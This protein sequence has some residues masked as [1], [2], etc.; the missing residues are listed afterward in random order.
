MLRRVISAVALIAVASAPV[1]ARTRLFCRF[2]G[3]EIT[4]CAEREIPAGIQADGCCDRQVT[5]PLAVAA[6]GHLP[7][8]APP[9]LNALPATFIAVAPAPLPA[10]DCAPRGGPP[11]FLIT[12]ALLI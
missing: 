3:V 8:I 12:R 4:D 11:V 10:H 1:V 7:E 2:T 9:V 5:Q 6:N